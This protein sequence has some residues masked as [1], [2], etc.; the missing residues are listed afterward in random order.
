MRRPRDLD[1]WGELYWYWFGYGQHDH[2]QPHL[3]LGGISSCCWLQQQRQIWLVFAIERWTERVVCIQDT[4]W[5][6]SLYSPLL[7]FFW[8][9]QRRGV[10]AG[11]RRRQSG[12]VLEKH[13]PH[14]SSA[15]WLIIWLFIY[16]P[17]HPFRFGLLHHK[18]FVCS[19]TLKQIFVK[20]VAGWLACQLLRFGLDRRIWIL[21]RIWYDPVNAYPKTG[22]L[23][24]RWTLNSSDEMVDWSRTGL[25]VTVLVDFDSRR[26]L[27]CLQS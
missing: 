15:G 11:F 3:H 2:R 23:A 4:T 9:Q 24:G 14:D 17:F 16:W 8:V 27:N 22:G 7:E 5:F 18:F 21:V 1:P 12:L 13:A 20:R 10:D 19:P 25:W 6:R 26:R